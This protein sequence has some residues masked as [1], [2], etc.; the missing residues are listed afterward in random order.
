MKLRLFT[1]IA[2]TAMAIIACNEDTETIGSSLTGHTDQLDMSTGVFHAI[3]R[4]IFADSVYAHSSTSYIGKIKDPETGAYVKSEFMTQFNMLENYRMPEKSKILGSYANGVAADSC[5]IILYFN[6]SESYGDSLAPVKVD[7][8]ELNEPMSDMRRYYSNFD[9]KSEG[10][11]KTSDVIKSHV[12]TMANL[13]YKDSIRNLSGYTDFARICLNDSYTDKNGITYNNYGTHIMRNFYEHPEYFK[14][15]YTFIHN[16]CPGFFFEV[17]DGL[18]VMAKLAEISMNVYYHYQGDTTVYYGVMNMSATPEVLQTTKITNDQKALARL[19]ADESCT[20]LK[21]PAGIFTEVTLPVEE[22]S[23]SHVGDSLLSASLSFQRQNSKFQDSDYLLQTPK[24][25]LMVQ[26]DSLHSFFE[27]EKLYDQICS[28]SATLTNNAY[29]F[30]NIGN[31]ITH[32]QQLRIKGV[33]EDPNWLVKHP[34]WNKVV[35]VPISTT[36]TKDSYGNNTVSAIGNN[37]GLSS[38]QLVGGPNSPIQINVIYAKF[39][40]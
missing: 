35:L 25:I 40:K 19:V 18:G 33:N 3:S 6:K 30:S 24:T 5:E 2:F 32:M 11:V 15:S 21:T 31:L 13:T 7:I 10:Y 36:S 29:T 8:Y 34:D 38:T 39:K 16:V 1:A 22:I 17:N 20:Y 27:Q 28:Y 9:P 12:F 26:K 14:N 4:S 23:Q 37:M